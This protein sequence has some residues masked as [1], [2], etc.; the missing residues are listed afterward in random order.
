LDKIEKINVG[1]PGGGGQIIQY[2]TPPAASQDNL[3]KIIQYTGTTNDNFTNG[4]FYKCIAKNSVYS[5]IETKV[6]ADEVVS[7]TQAEFD[8]LSQ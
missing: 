2:D 5:W 6:N 1:A 7:I 8:A 4:Y 3:G